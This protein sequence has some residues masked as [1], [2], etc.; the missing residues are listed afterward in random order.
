MSSKPVEPSF[1]KKGDALVRSNLALL[2]LVV[3]GIASIPLYEIGRQ[4]W[5]LGSHTITVYWLYTPALILYLVAALIF[6]RSKNLGMAALYVILILGFASRATLVTAGPFFSSDI[7]RYVWDGRVQAAG[8]NPYIYIPAD[9]HLESLR[10]AE[11][12]PSINRKEYAPTLY[13]PGAQVIF[14]ATYLIGGMSVTAMKL[15]MLFFE[16]LTTL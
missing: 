14:L 8:I 9:K 7:N 3:I 15:S 16:G 10:D 13:P 2:T 6:W 5:E 1:I 12:Y 4:P 11:V